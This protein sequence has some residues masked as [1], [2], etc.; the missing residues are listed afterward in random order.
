MRGGDVS[1]SVS[2]LVLEGIWKGSK[3]EGFRVSNGWCIELESFKE[4]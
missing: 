1:V 4:T 2:V 3:V